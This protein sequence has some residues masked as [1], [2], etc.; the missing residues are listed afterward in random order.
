MADFTREEVR[1]QLNVQGYDPP[2][3]EFTEVVYRINALIDG[4]KQLDHLEVYHVEPW[5]VMP[6]RSTSIR[7]MSDAPRRIQSARV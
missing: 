4:L 6:P 7:L 3:P 1:S 5:P 2:E